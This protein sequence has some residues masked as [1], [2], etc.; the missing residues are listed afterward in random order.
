[1]N[2]AKR[3]GKRRG[4]FSKTTK[5][6][7]RALRGFFRSAGMFFKRIFSRIGEVFSRFSK[8][9]LA[10]AGGCLVIA[11]AAVITLCLTLGGTPANAGVDASPNDENSLRQS[12]S[13]TSTLFLMSRRMR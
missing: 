12:R 11:V 3:G 7:K 6:I 9:T 2:S 10:I 1:M 8:K 4:S 13:M 5:K